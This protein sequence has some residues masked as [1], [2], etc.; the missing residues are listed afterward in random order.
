MLSAVIEWRAHVHGEIQLA[1]PNREAHVHMENYTHTG[2]TENTVTH[3]ELEA[4]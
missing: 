4:I 2:T 3:I 1:T